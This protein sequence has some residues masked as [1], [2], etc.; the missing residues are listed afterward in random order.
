MNK[1]PLNPKVR[2]MVA[3]ALGKKRLPTNIELDHII[4]K[5]AGGKDVLPNLQFL[6]K[7]QHQIKTAYENAIRARLRKRR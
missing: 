2:K 4:P 6:T 5:W 3:K 1:R 7:K